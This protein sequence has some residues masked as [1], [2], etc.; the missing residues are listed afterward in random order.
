MK[1]VPNNA[2]K[3][4]GERVRGGVVYRVYTFMCGWCYHQMIA[5]ILGLIYLRL[6]LDQVGV[7]NFNGVLFL[8]LTNVSFNNLFGVLNVS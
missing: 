5:T 8:F 4:G 2:F 1:V 7:M 6:S 3:F